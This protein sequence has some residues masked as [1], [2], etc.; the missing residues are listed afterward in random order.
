MI[1]NSR[2]KHHRITADVD[3]LPAPNEDYERFEGWNERHLA[4]GE[5]GINL[6]RKKAYINV[7]NEIIEVGGGEVTIDVT[8]IID[9][10]DGTM[11]FNSDNKV[12]ETADIHYDK[13][14]DRLGIGYGGIGSLGAQLDIKAKGVLTSDLV[15][16][17]K[18]STGGA[19]LDI[20]PE[21]GGMGM[22]LTGGVFKII[23]NYATQYLISNSIINQV[24]AYNGQLN[25]VGGSN[26]NL[27]NGGLVVN[28]NETYIATT[29]I[30]IGRVAGANIRVGINNT[31]DKV[32]FYGV[33]PIL[34]PLKPDLGLT[35]NTGDADTDAII[36]ALIDVVLS[37]GLSRIS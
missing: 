21:Y 33:T 10:Q 8:P 11:L 12:S 16:S 36:N 23:G 19:G 31:N 7:N 1:V 24:N 4:E 20:Y 37:T 34:Q 6:F 27:Q 28:N 30:N 3:F 32:G 9:G 2:Y 29:N 26:V 22:S 15:T 5:I 17:I 35:P 13:S 25:L 14:T 18:T